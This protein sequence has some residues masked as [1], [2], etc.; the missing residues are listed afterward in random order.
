MAA[1]DPRRVVADRLDR[2][3]GAPVVPGC[4]SKRAIDEAPANFGR[5][6]PVLAR[7]CAL[8]LVERLPQACGVI[9]L[10]R[11]RGG[12]G[13]MQI[14]E[15]EQMVVDMRHPC[16]RDRRPAVA[17]I[18]SRKFKPPQK[19]GSVDTVER[20]VIGQL[21]RGEAVV[22]GENLVEPPL[23]D[24]KEG[25]MPAVVVGH[26]MRMRPIAPVSI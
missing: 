9:G 23:L 1:A 2:F 24:Q 14:V 7:P 5:H 17:D 3:D 10:R 16:V 13:A 4:E 19:R 20:R 25:K 18:D 21:R 8:V 22:V 6:L 15:G 11:T 26:E 12:E